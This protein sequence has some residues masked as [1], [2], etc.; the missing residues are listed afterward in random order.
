[1]QLILAVIL[2]A[3]AVG[4]ALSALR[5]RAPLEP[6]LS[7]LEPVRLEAARWCEFEIVGESHHQPALAAIAGSDPEGVNHHCQ[8][9][10]VLDPTNPH[11]PNAVRVILEGRTVGHL[12]RDDAADYGERLAELGVA[13]RPALCPAYICGGFLLED[14]GRASYGV[15]LG[16]AWPVEL[17]KPAESNS[18]L[19]AALIARLRG[20]PLTEEE[21]WS[22][23]PVPVA[24]DAELVRAFA[25]GLQGRAVAFAGWSEDRLPYLRA[26]LQAAG[27]ALG[28][29]ATPGLALLCV[30][31]RPGLDDIAAA[32]AGGAALVSGE[33]LQRLMA[34][35]DE[36]T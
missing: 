1:M 21:A 31:P 34:G 15:K 19:S 30:G 35:A 4:L 16:L 36:A 7:G 26:V 22:A 29:V 17:E 23:P 2:A 24:D 28:E 6:D 9:V 14:G 8:A 27:L 32:K 11:D 3:A 18:S 20:A 33:Q 12:G 25:G 10:L 5:A 13:G